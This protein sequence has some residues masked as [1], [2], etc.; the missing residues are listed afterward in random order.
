[1]KQ[2]YTKP[3][4]MME[5]FTLTQTVASGCGAVPGG[6]TTGRPAHWSKS[7]CGWEVGSDIIWVEGANSNC[8]FDWGVD[9]EI[10]G[11]CYNN[12]GGGNSIFTS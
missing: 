9:D 12:P 7:T 11:I 1:M 4:L 2:L 8:N 10:E 3:V 5:H 6:N